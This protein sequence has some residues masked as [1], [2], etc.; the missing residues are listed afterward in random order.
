MALT[1]LTFCVGI[2]IGL[3]YS[4]LALVPAI[5]G[6]LCLPVLVGDGIGLQRVGVA[7]LQIVSIQGGYMIGL[8]GRDLVR[9]TFSRLSVVMRG[10]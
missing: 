6:I 9:S 4:F 8:T 7:I 1:A 10:S 3:R 5:F 2:A